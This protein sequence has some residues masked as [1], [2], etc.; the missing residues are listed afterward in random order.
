MFV[1]LKLSTMMDVLMLFPAGAVVQTT[2]CSFTQPLL[3]FRYHLPHGCVSDDENASVSKRYCGR[4]NVRAE[5][6]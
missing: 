4:F 3:R 2:A 1:L 6:T 5:T